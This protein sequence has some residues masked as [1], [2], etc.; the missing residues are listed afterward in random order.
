MFSRGQIM[1]KLAAERNKSIT[2]SKTDTGQEQYKIQGSNL[3]KIQEEVKFNSVEGNV[4]KDSSEDKGISPSLEVNA[5]VE[6]S[7]SEGELSDFIDYDDPRDPDYKPEKRK[8]NISSSSNTS[9]NEDSR[10]TVNT[11]INTIEV[12]GCK[13]NTNDPL[14]SNDQESQKTV[15]VNIQTFV[16]AQGTANEDDVLPVKMSKE[17]T[18]KHKK[19]RMHGKSYL[20][21]KRNNN[22]KKE[23]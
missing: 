18:T 1:I 7:C 10:G 13:E 6:S 8:R 16:G 3:I 19:L 9:E 2:P 21:V 11:Q 23:Y 22:G 17:S 5:I 4:I 20:G 15:N 12:Q 14:L